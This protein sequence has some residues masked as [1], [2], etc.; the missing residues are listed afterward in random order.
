M[1]AEV[2]HGR[3]VLID[4]E[5]DIRKVLSGVLSDE[6]H[7]VHSA[8]SAA[9]GLEMVSDKNPDLVLLDVWLPD[10]DG[11]EVLGRIRRILPR[12][13]VIMISGHASI[14]TAVRATREG[15][16]DFLEKPLGLEKVLVSVQTALK[17]A[18]L[19]DENASLRGRIEERYRL[20]GDSP[21]IERIRQQ[22]DRIGRAQSTVLVTGENGTGKE[23]VSRSIHAVSQRSHGPFVAVN[24]A[25]IPDE[26]MESELFGHEKGAFTGAIA[27]HRGRFEMAHGGTI[28]LDEIGDMSLRTQ[29]KL[30]RVLQD[31]AVERLGGSKPIRVDV[32]VVAATNKDLAAEISQGQFRED[33]F[34]RL[35]V[36]PIELPPLRERGSDIL[37]LARHFMSEFCIENGEAVKEFSSE[38]E[39]VLLSHRWPGN[40][41]E[42]KNLMERLSIL[43]PSHRVDG[44]DLLQCGLSGFSGDQTQVERLP[45][46][47][48]DDFRVAKAQFEKAF[49]MAKLSE[50]GQNVSR[51]ADRIGMERS[52][53]Y[54]KLK[55]LGVDIPESSHQ[56]LHDR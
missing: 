2:L 15:A 46:L 40:V 16:I 19:S 42:L 41:R 24:C 25:A 48:L 51:T 47:V 39:S 28:F 10:G 33:L 56:P 49:I 38:A 21:A 5:P 34:Y 23:N 3:I 37:L 12:T 54:R 50:C 45:W 18:R 44:R 1:N 4:D 22:I 7:E 20:I 52:H 36:L 11:L 35:N 31:R 8:G 55:Q 9:Q 17:L 53:L 14:E 32:R 27:T 13:L 29:S 26:L 43:V 30:L 6:G